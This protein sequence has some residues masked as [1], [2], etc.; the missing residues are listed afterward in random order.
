MKKRI[1]SLIVAAITL[2]V[3]FASPDAS[4]QSWRGQKSVGLRGGF[5]TRNTTATAGLYFSYRFTEHFRFA[6]KVDYAFRHKGIDAF[7]FNFDTEMPIALDGTTGRVNFYPIAGL[8][9]STFTSHNDEG[10]VEELDENND[11]SSQRTSRF[12]LNFGAGIE[13]FATPT[14][15]LAFESKFLLMKQYSGGWFNVSI[16]YVF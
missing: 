6:P 12:G 8:N 2:M 10:P 7:S 9:Y 3:T 1:F 16:G 4:A 14:L 15:R 5:T 13:Y 11:D